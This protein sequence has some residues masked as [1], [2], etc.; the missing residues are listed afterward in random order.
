SGM[1]KGKL[2]PSD[3]DDIGNYN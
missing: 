2:V 1:E 3:D